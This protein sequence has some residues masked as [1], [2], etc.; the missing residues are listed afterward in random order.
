MDFTLIWVNIVY[1]KRPFKVRK[2]RKQLLIQLGPTRDSYRPQNIDKVERRR[3][4]RC[5]VCQGV[6]RKRGH[7][8]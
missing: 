1:V 6:I 7:A 4:L 3:M 8:Y 2:V 5:A